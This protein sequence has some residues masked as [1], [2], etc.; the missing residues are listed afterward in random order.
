MPDYTYHDRK[1]MKWMPFNALLEQGDYINDLLHG[2][3]RKTMPVLSVDQLE[4][5]N[6][7]LESAYLF[8]YEIE[9]SYFESHKIKKVKGHITRTDL[10]NKLIFIGEKSVSALQITNI[11]VI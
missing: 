10:F 5:L 4:E 6:R 9:V 2:R 8:N 7:Q 3:E 1:M 11:E